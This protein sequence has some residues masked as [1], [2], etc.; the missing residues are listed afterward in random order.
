MRNVSVNIVRLIMLIVLLLVSGCTTP[1]MNA[2]G[3]GDI[4]TMRTLIEHGADVNEASDYSALSLAV[5]YNKPK[6]VLFL[7]EQGADVNGNIRDSSFGSMDTAVQ[8]G[9]TEMLKLL[10]DHGADVNADSPLLTAFAYQ[11]YKKAAILV[12]H[13]ADVNVTCPTCYEEYRVSPFILAV[14]RGKTSLVRLMLEHSAD[15]N[16]TDRSGRTATAIARASGNTLLIKLL[17]RSEHQALGIYDEAP[18]TTTPDSA[19]PAV[20]IRPTSDVDINIPRTRVKNPDAI[21]V[22]IGN[23]KYA[24]TKKVEYAINDAWAV[25]QYLINAFGYREGNIFLIENASKSDFE[26]FFG[27]EKTHKGK[28]FNAVR[29]GKSDVFV[30][31]SGHGAP[32]LKDKKGYFVPTEADPQY[33]ELS[34]YPADVFYANLSKIPARTMTVVIDA[35]FSGATVFENISPM[36]IKIDKTVAELSNGVVLSSSSGTQVSSW[37]NEKQHGMFTYFFLKSIQDRNADANRD[38]SLTYSEIYRYISDNSYGVPY[39]ARRIHGVEQNPT[40]E[41][42]QTDKVLV[43]Y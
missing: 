34:G 13:G 19:P 21:A 40:I 24:K 15:L 26:V 9:T 31:Y 38:G 11:K 28:L 20:S 4:E 3:Q 22:V 33:L 25:K 37:Y 18:K 10:I 29:A 41:G 5:M 12:Q 32:G 36:L 35:C 39:Y 1:L 30:Y 16:S 42:Q 2:A 7:L 23:S 43:R 14:Q 8:H 17:E 27:N 6:A